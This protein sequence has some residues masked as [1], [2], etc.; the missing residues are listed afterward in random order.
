M[1]L[2]HVFLTLSSAKPKYRSNRT[3]IHG[4]RL[5]ISIFYCLW[6]QRWEPAPSGW[7]GYRTEHRM[8]DKGVNV[9]G[10]FPYKALGKVASGNKKK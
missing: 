2:K 10:V 1:A 6:V 5:C 4:I 3:G 9:N 7:D 8:N